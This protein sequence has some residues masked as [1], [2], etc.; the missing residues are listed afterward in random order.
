M[1]IDV[2][3][4]NENHEPE[5]RVF[6]PGACLSSLANGQ[7][8]QEQDSVCLRFIDAYGDTV[9]NRAQIPFLLQEMERSVKSQTDP[10]TKKRL[11]KVC[12]LVSK[13]QDKLHMYVK[14]IGD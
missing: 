9:F 7:W 4:V 2:A 10:E 13:A 8:A 11:Q 6:D 3:I 1:G 5:Q 12:R 14:F